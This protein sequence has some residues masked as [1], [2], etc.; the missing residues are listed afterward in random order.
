MYVFESFCTPLDK[1]HKKKSCSNWKTQTEM[2]AR[3]MKKIKK[4]DKRS[5]Y[6]P[7]F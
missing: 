2:G 4:L 6:N 3:N 5:S 7:V 1:E